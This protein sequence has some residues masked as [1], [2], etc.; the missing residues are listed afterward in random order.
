MHCAISLR[1]HHKNK[2]ERVLR[3][4]RYKY[5]AISYEKYRWSVLGGKSLGS[6]N[7]TRPPH[8]RQK[9]EQTLDKVWPPMLQNKANSTVLRPYFC[10]Y[11]LGQ[12]AC[13]TRLPPKSF[14]FDM[15]NG[16]KNEKKDPKSDL[17]C[18]RECLA[19]L[20][21]LKLKIFHR[22]V[23]KSS[24]PRKTWK[25]KTRGSASI[26]SHYSAVGNT[27]SCDAPYS[28]IGFKGKLFLRYP[29]VRPVFGLR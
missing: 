28:A 24:S 6:P 2:H 1:R 22:H 18:D 29:L 12:H 25:K 5:R 23:S 13:R 15:K 20:R 8:A 14:E 9:Y 16:S 3:Y 21:P 26:V 10:S 4:C 17:K 7:V 11:F 27:I 19:P